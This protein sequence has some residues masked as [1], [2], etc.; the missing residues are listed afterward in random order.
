MRRHLFS[1]ETIIYIIV[2][3]LLFVAPILMEAYQVHSGN[4]ASF[5]WTGIFRAWLM[6]LPFVI[7]FVLHN[8]LLAPMLIYKRR[9][10]AYAAW[11]LGLIALFMSYQ[12][13][14]RPD[15]GPHRHGPPNEV[16]EGRRPPLPHDDGLRPHDRHRGQRPPQMHEGHD[17]PPLFLGQH[18]IISGILLVLML[19]M[20]LGVKLYVRQRMQEL[21]MA[22]RERRTLQQQLEYLKYQINPHFLMNT[23]NN[24]H[25]LIDID[26]AEAQQMIVDLS[27]LLR[28]VLY[29]GAKPLVPLSREVQFVRDYITL[30]RQRLDLLFPGRYTLDIADTASD[31]RVHLVFPTENQD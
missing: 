27:H 4:V 9:R 24:I 8:R 31:Y 26:P 20:N 25:A 19:G 17:E 14:H 1:H 3:A 11:V 2:W 15:D 29:E 16:A 18:D 30:M 13:S 5:A 7:V 23:L 6:F 28:F 21:E 12:C 10:I 22:E